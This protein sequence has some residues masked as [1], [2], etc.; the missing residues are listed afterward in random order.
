[1]SRRKHQVVDSLELLLDTICNTFGGVVFIAILVIILLQLSGDAHDKAK[2]SDDPVARQLQSR[3]TEL[4]EHRT[5]L[6]E[7]QQ[8]QL[9]TLKLLAPENLKDLLDQTAA[10][11][12]KRLKLEAELRQLEQQRRSLQEQRRATAVHL[13]ASSRTINE[14]QREV[15][16]LQAELQHQR[17]ARKTVLRTTVLHSPGFRQQVIL[18]AQYDRLYVWHRYSASGERLGLNTEEFVILK[19][20]AG[21]IET[22]PNPA[23][24]TQLQE[25]PDA[26]RKLLSRLKQFRPEEVYLAIIVR[27]DTYDTFRY[28]RDTVVEAGFEYRLEPTE[29]D[30]EFVDRGGADGRVQ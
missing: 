6:E 22:S 24:G 3:L 2:Q 16:A 17:D 21:S 10:Q 12:T 14:L 7:L 5:R 26:R 11:H 18:I 25:G 23:T 29:A 9:R 8:N 13:Q 19:H 28:L 20:G 15:Q 30:E 27:P 4:Q 1:M